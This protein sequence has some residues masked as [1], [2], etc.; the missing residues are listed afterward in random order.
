MG[1]QLW[2]KERQYDVV[3]EGAYIAKVTEVH[4]NPSDTYGP[5]W[6]FCFEILQ[7]PFAGKI[8]WWK[9]SATWSEGNKLDVGLRA[10]GVTRQIGEVVDTDELIGKS[11]QVFVRNVT[12]RSKAGA[13]PPTYSNVKEVVMLPRGTELPPAQTPPGPTKDVKPSVP[14]TTQQGGG[15]KQIPW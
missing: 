11:A 12:G 13:P 4:E 1:Y 10:L 9:V 7:G 2:K 8:V 6:N 5:T 3:D 15:K 14:S